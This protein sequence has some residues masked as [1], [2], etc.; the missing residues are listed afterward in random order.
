MRRKPEEE[1]QVVDESE[2]KP[3]ENALSLTPTNELQ[4]SE[5]CPVWLSPGPRAR[6][7]KIYIARLISNASFAVTE[8][9]QPKV[10]GSKTRNARGHHLQE[11]G[12]A[13]A[14][15][16]RRTLERSLSPTDTVFWSAPDQKR[17]SKSVKGS[18][19]ER[20][21]RPDG[22]GNREALAGG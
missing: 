11:C 13:P 10:H 22:L 19:T 5:K 3:P 18:Q 15:S 17:R 1:Q 4:L 21:E 9:L 2:K 20:T 16:R 6:G 12:R 8:K 7:T 14:S